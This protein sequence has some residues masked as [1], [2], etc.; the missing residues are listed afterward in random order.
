MAAYELFFSESNKSK[1]PSQETFCFQPLFANFAAPAI[2]AFKMKPTFS[3]P[4]TLLAILGL[5]TA[6]VL[7]VEERSAAAVLP[8]EERSSNVTDV[9]KRASCVLHTIWESNWGDGAYHRYRVHG[10]A[11]GSFGVTN[12]YEMIRQWCT[13]FKRMFRLS[14]H[15][16]SPRTR[17]NTNETLTQG[18][19]KTRVAPTSPSF[20]IL[21]A[22][23]VSSPTRPGAT[24][25][26]SRG[27][28][29]I[30]STSITTRPS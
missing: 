20:R 29:A 4:F 15:V 21:S 9:D 5:A 13:F 3:I 1:R 22:A 14:F 18:S 11:E 16:D 6:A 19:Q 26:L 8:V 10:W 12:S 23:P 25:A 7:P 2:T 24:L 30:R 17:G 27:P 28:T